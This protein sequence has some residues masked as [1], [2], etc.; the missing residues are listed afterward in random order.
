MD[1]KHACVIDAQNLY[2]TFVLVLVMENDEGQEEQIQHYE[3]MD[4]EQL[5]DTSPPT[6]RPYAG[7]VGFIRPKW[8]A[9]A[10]AW[11][12]WARPISRPSSV[13]NEFSAIFWDLKGAVR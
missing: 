9:A 13:M 10:S 1:Y 6:M 12:A 5:V 8:D 7:A 11:T 3:L 4:G 2:K